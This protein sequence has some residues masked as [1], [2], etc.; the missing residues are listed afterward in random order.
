[1]KQFYGMSKAGVLRDAV[2]GLADPK[3]IILLSNPDQFERHVEELEK[4]YP[5]VPSIGC[6]AMGYDTSVVE[7]GV[8]SHISAV[9]SVNCLFR[10]QGQL[11]EN[12]IRT[13]Y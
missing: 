1:M 6:I 5:G 13:P 3:L 7:K 10:Y 12:Y 11:K 8:A 2:Q 9:F 4:L